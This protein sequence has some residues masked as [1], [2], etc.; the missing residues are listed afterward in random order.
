MRS[1]D[2][3]GS[4]DWAS[5]CK[6]GGHWFHFQSGHT[7]GLPARSR[8]GGVREAVDQCFAP[9]LSPSLP[10]SLKIRKGRERGRERREKRRH[11]LFL[12]QFLLIITF[13]KTNTVSQPGCWHW[14]TVLHF[15]AFTVS[16]PVNF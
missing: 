9:S 8:I 5:S 7:P 15:I 2:W 13:C 6:L 4:V 12:T 11:S 14:H 1:P 10:L 3:C 16:P